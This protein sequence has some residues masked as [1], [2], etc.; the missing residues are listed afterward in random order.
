MA[1]RIRRGTENERQV[2]ALDNGEVAW[3]SDTQ[4]MYVG[5]GTG[6]VGNAGM[7]NILSTSAGNGLTFNPSTH[8]LD[9]NNTALNLTTTDVG[10][11][12]NQYYTQER[13]QDAAASL[14]TT[15]VHSGISFTYQST[16]DNANR[17]DASVSLALSNLTDVLVSGTPVTGDTLKWNGSK[18]V[19]GADQNTGIPTVSA[20][21][22]PSLGGNLNLNGFNIRSTS[23]D[24]TFGTTTTGNN[25]VVIGNQ[26]TPAFTVRTG[27]TGTGGL[28]QQG[29]IIRTYSHNGTDSS[30]TPLVLNDSLGQLNFQGRIKAGSYGA[31]DADLVSIKAIVNYEGDLVSAITTAALEFIVLNGP[32]TADA[33]L[34]TFNN[35]GVFSAPIMQTGVYTSTPETRPTGVKG[36][37]IFNDTTSKFQGYNGTTWVDLN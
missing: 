9:I 36:M 37:I 33:K 28:E 8:Q 10:E 12:I 17:I 15:G 29:P 23:T 32:N 31:V 2:T 27:L 1:L 18:W 35:A 4:K 14:L 19:P 22:S 30:P 34:A 24:I 16:Q 6:Q 20:D 7:V 21:T 3:T 5:L 26:A 25:L 11:G 13:A